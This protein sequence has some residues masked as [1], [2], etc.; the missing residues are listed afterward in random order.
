MVSCRREHGHTSYRPLLQANKKE[1]RGII[2]FLV[3]EG[4]GGQE[5]HRRMEAMYGE[6]S[7]CHSRVVNWRKRFFVRR[8]LLEDDVRPGEAHRVIT[9]ELI[10]EMNALVLDNRR[11]SS[12]SKTRTSIYNGQRSA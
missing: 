1:Q 11:T 4:V 9:P 3:A 5:L 8:E 6:Y 2:R 10:A 7:L 12:T